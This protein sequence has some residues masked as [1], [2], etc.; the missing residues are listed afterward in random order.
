MKFQKKYIRSE[1]PTQIEDLRRIIDKLKKLRHEKLQKV[2]YLNQDLGRDYAWYEHLSLRPYIL[3]NT[4][5]YTPVSED[6]EWMDV[7]TP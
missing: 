5:V 1:G 6:T 3:L 7:Q 2:I 4:G